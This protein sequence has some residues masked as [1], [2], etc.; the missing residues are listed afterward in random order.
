MK[1]LKWIPILYDSA[2][3]KNQ[4]NNEKLCE[5]NEEES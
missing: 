2:I 4:P 1:M 5:E 3:K